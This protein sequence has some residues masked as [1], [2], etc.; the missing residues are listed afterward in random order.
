MNAI[1]PDCACFAPVP[2]LEPRP[3]DKA[4]AASP[5]KVGD[6]FLLNHCCCVQQA[7]YVPDT[8]QDGFGCEDHSLCFCCRSD[9]NGLQLPADASGYE[10]LLLLSGQCTCVKP[11]CK[12]R[13]S[14]RVFFAYLKY[15]FPT[16]DEVPCAVV[17]CGKKCCGSKRIEAGNGS[18]LASSL[19]K[20]VISAPTAEAMEREEAT[21]DVLVPKGKKI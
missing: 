18:W 21:S 1:V 3:T 19:P 13:G 15:S 6:L 12:C 9:L 8:F 14:T 7:A 5:A 10:L 4:F 11:R 16:D 17:A 2:R 20:I